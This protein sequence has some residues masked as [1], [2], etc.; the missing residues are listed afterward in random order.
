MAGAA[1][2]R[3]RARRGCCARQRRRATTAPGTPRRR[4]PAATARTTREVRSPGHCLWGLMGGCTMF[5]VHVRVNMVLRMWP[6]AHESNML[7][8][9]AGARTA[10]ACHVAL[11]SSNPKPHLG[12]QARGRL[13]RRS[14]TSALRRGAATAAC[15]ADSAAAR[16]CARST[17]QPRRR[18]C[19]AGAW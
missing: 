10:A 14:W 16:A 18:R 9:C 19:G 15:C 2:R 13:R 7:E 4:W 5:N 8:P 1:A 17:A 3:A 12:R 6:H 11:S